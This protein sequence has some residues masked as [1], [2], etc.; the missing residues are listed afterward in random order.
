VGD[1]IVDIARKYPVRSDRIQNQLVGIGDTETL[2][3]PRKHR[4]IV[5]HIADRNDIDLVDVVL[6]GEP[7]QPAGLAHAR[8]GH[9]EQHRSRGRVRDGDDPGKFLSDLLSDS[10]RMSR[11]ILGPPGKE[12]DDISW[13]DEFHHRPGLQFR[14]E[15]Q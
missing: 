4:Q 1:S 5:G 14:R 9:L 8:F 11:M 10:V 3:G 7:L 13:R 12:F 6:S 2:P 15:G